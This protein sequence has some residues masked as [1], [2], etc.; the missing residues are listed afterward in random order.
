[1]HEPKRIEEKIIEIEAHDPD[2][3]QD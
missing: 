3:P 2:K 1:M